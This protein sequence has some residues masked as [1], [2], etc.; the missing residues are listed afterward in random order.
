VRQRVVAIGLILLAA[1]AIFAIG[2]S[3]QTQ[4]PN[5][6]YVNQ[7]FQVAGTH[8]GVDVTEYRLYRA[9]TRVATVPASARNATTGEVLFPS[10]TETAVSTGVL[11]EM[12]AA[13]VNTSGEA[14]S[15]RTP[16]T[17]IVKLA[18]PTAPAPLTLPKIIRIP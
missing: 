11:Y 4:A 5:E 7:A 16:L 3:A 9:N 6:V 13:N 1:L 10:R 17:V 8:T 14:E 18:P 12:T 2:A 15:T